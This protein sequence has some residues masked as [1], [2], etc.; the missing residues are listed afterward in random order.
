MSVIA[1]APYAICH[2]PHCV[3]AMLDRTRNGDFG[4]TCPSW[5]ERANYLHRNEQHNGQT[6]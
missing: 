3:Y 4:R 2:M 6:V 1:G 5:G